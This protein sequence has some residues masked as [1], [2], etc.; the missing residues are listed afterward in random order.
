MNKPAKGY[1]TVTKGNNA[2][3]FSIFVKPQD[4]PS[5]TRALIG[6]VHPTEYNHYEGRPVN[7]HGFPRFT[8]ASFDASYPVGMVNLSDKT[9]PVK[10]KITGFNPLIPGD[11]DASGLPVAVLTYEVT[12]T[13][14]EPI[15]VSVCG[16]V[17]NFIGK[18]GSKFHTDWKGDYIPDGAKNNQNV[19]RQNRDIQG[20]YM[21][22]DSVQ[23]TDAAY[24]TIALTTTDKSGVSYRRSSE[25]NSWEKAT[26]DFW[27]D[28]SAD[29]MLTDKTRLFDDDPMASLAVKKKIAP[30]ESRLF[31]FYI[32]WNFP[33]RYAWSDEIVGN[34]Y[35]TKYADAWD[36][37]IK[38]IPQIP[39]LEQKTKMFLNAFLSSSYPDPVKKRHFLI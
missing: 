9:M 22:S 20:I 39:Q 29:G 35:S 33:N 26:L 21:Y 30:G 3:F 25:A 24:G 27:D 18:D 36:A 8:N 7:Q 1:S 32:T 4:K 14:N 16:T 37:A 23:K 31:S 2:P 19:Y 12:N 15:E 11:A 5:I 13:T 28:F 6:P 10:V 38:I 17:R 34:Y